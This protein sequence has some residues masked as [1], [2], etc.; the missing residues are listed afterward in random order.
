MGAG[1]VVI[2]SLQSVLTVVVT[3]AGVCAEVVLFTPGTVPVTGDL[4]NTDTAGPV[5]SLPPQPAR[6]NPVIIINPAT[7]QGH[8]GLS[9]IS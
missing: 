6:S 4:Q 1:V 5:G 9:V 2:E 3:V 8:L 7:D